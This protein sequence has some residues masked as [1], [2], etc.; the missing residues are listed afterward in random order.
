MIVYDGLYD[1]IFVFWVVMVIKVLICSNKW[2]VI[3]YIVFIYI[4]F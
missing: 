3:I 4:K 1:K 2:I